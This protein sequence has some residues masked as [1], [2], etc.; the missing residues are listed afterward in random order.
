MKHTLIKLIDQINWFI[1]KNYRFRYVIICE[2][3]TVISL[4]ART[5]SRKSVDYVHRGGLNHLKK[6][7]LRMCSLRPSWKT[8]HKWRAHIFRA[9]RSAIY[10]KPDRSDRYGGAP[11]KAAGCG[12]RN[13]IPHFM[14]YAIDQLAGLSYGAA[15]PRDKVR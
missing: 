11:G 14:F 4:T 3:K 9:P 5:L 8:A 13:G 12:L 15:R 1:Y 10:F 2:I 7:K 6:L